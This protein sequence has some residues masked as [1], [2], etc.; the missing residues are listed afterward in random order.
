MTYAFTHED[1][2]LLLLLVIRSWDLGGGRILAQALTLRVGPIGWKLSLKVGWVMGLEAGIWVLRL[3]G[4]RR[5]RRRRNFPMCESKGH[6]PHLWGHCPKRKQKK[7]KEES[8]NEK[9]GERQKERKVKRM[10]Q[11]EKESEKKRKQEYKKE[12]E[13]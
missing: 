6:W 11:K 8:M 1:L 4:V 7:K 9:D 2:F 3:G 12:K 5:R 10:R 13:K